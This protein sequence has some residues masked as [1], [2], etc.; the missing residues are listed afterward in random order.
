MKNADFGRYIRSLREKK[1]IP[2]RLVAHKLN[3][4]TSS[5]SKIELGERPLTLEMIPGLAEIL[6]VDF[7][8]LQIKYISEKILIDYKDQPLLSEALNKSQKALKI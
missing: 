2:Q 7:K 8:N 4:D 6:E 3:I 1:N 5:L